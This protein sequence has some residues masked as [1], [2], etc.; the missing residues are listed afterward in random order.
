M[1][2][3]VGKKEAMKNK[4]KKRVVSGD[5]WENGVMEAGKNRGG[6]KE[7][8]ERNGERIQWA[9]TSQSC[10]NLTMVDKVGNS[11]FG[12]HTVIVVIVK[13]IMMIDLIFMFLNAVVLGYVIYLWKLVSKPMRFKQIFLGIIS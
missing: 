6:E 5:K 1:N 13:I 7:D 8:A 10:P 4:G 3:E 9:S 11:F 12:S 2:Q